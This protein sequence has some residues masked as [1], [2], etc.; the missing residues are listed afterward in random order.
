MAKL[1]HLD[2]ENVKNIWEKK[3]CDQRGKKESRVKEIKREEIK[4]RRKRE[5][6]RKK[7]E[8]EGDKEWK[9]EGEIKRKSK[10]EN[11]KRGE[12]KTRKWKREGENKRMTEVMRKIAANLWDT[13]HDEH[14]E[15]S[16]SCII[17]QETWPA[18]KTHS[19]SQRNNHKFPQTKFKFPTI[20]KT[21]FQMELQPQ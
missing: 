13:I 8:R 15:I 2:E 20:Q 5:L 21:N 6:D 19:Q 18:N 9:R 7:W 14:Q 11:E 4:R 17:K 1:K 3:R 10:R 12:E 16:T